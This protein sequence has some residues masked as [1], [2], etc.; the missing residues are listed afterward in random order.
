ML[1]L[2]ETPAGAYRRVAVDARIRG[3][4]PAELVALCFEQLDAELGAALRA[5]GA[6]DRAR[7]SD[8]LLRAHAAL[9]ALE[10]G[11]DPAAPLATTLRQLYAAGR[12][13]LLDSVARF[14]PPALAELRADMAEVGTAMTGAAAG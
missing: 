9:T 3:A 13:R 5:D 10:M 7:R 2:R 8:A 4:R 14:D 11:L 12:A 6:G 1:H